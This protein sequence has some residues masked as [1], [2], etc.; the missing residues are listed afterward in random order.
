MAQKFSKPF[1]NSRQWQECRA[2]YIASVF[3]LC[4]RCNVKGKI[5]PGYILH[6]KILLT[7]NNIN[8]PNVTLNHNNLYYVCKDC[9]EVEHH[10]ESEV[11]REGLEFDSEGNVV[12][13]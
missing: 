8:D 12:E 7:P 1:Y 4:E 13:R 6:H 2:S 9:H 5:T 3:N 10:G 11:I